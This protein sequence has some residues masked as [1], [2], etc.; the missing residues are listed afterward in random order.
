MKK[1]AL[2]M[3]AVVSM[4]LVSCGGGKK[5]GTI[6]PVSEKINGPLGDFFEVVAKEYKVTDRGTVSIELK[7]IKDGFPA[8]WNESMKV[9]YD[10]GYYEPLFTAEFQDKDGNTLTKDKMDIVFDREDL[11]GV[12]ALRVNESTTLE[13]DVR[14][15]EAC[16]VKISSTFEVHSASESSYFHNNDEIGM[17]KETSPKYVVVNATNL[18]LRYGPSLE[19]DTYKGP[20]GKN[21]HVDKGECFPYLDEEGDFYKIDYNGQELWVA[22]EFT[23]LSDTYVTKSDSDDD[24]YFSPSEDGSADWDK[25]LD[26][27]E[28]Y[29]NKYYS[30]AE[31]VSKGNPSAMA[32]ALSMSEKAASLA[33]KLERAEDNLS[34][35]QANRL[36]KIQNKMAQ[37]AAKMAGAA[38]NVED[39]MN[40]IENMDVEDLLNN[41]PNF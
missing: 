17:D 4:A 27:Y 8:P 28:Q 21:Q 29:V 34:T 7:R 12:A 15:K 26:E 10:D 31:K 13:F 16:K 6:K 37:A 9:G 23:Y 35:S 19:D 18:R 2:I 36:L 5:S 30:F 38:S 40:D 33:E 24:D 25:I 1:L 22:K 14:D 32:D 41:L 11:E 20:D 3:L 39:M